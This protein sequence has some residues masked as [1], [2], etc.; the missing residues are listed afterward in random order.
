MEGRAKHAAGVAIPAAQDEAATRHADHGQEGIDGGIDAASLAS[1]PKSRWP[2]M[3]DRKP[4]EGD[5]A[6]RPNKRPM[7]VPSPIL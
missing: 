2:A 4:V 1:L 5:P 3:G 6:G 7:K